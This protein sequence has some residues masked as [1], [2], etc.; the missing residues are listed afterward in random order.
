MKVLKFGGTSVGTASGRDNICTLALEKNER[1]IVVVSALSGVTDSLLAL[2]R[3]AAAGNK[4]NYE[5][6]LQALRK[7]HFEAIEQSTPIY[8]REEIKD[9][10]SS[11]IDKLTIEADEIYKNRELTAVADASVV[12]Y[13]ERLSSRILA[14]MMDDCAHIDSTQIIKTTPY[15]NRHIVDFPQT[16]HLI[17]EA[18]SKISSRIIVMGGFISSEAGNNETTNLGRGG[19]DYTAAIVA[20][21]LGVSTLYI[22]TDVDGFLSSDPRIVDNAILIEEL[23]FV[24]AMELCNFGAKV[25]YPPTIF[26]AYNADI[27]IVIRST[28]NHKCKGTTI[29][30]S[31]LMTS[32]SSVFKGISSINDTALLSIQGLK[33]FG[34]VGINYRLF[35]ALSAEGIS[36]FMVSQSSSNNITKVAIKNG[37]TQRAMEVIRSEF[38][39]E[40]ERGEIDECSVERNLAIIAVVGASLK[41]NREATA[42]ILNI[43]SDNGI[44]IIAS[45]QGGTQNSIAFVTEL[46]SLRRA[47]KVLHEALFIK[48]YDEVNIEIVGNNALS[49]TIKELVENSARKIME[50]YG[51][52][53]EISA[54]NSG[55]AVIV[56]CSKD[57]NLNYNELLN[58][59]KNIVSANRRAA[60]IE[61]YNHATSKYKCSATVGE[62]LPIMRALGDMVH[63]GD[64]INEIKGLVSGVIN[65]AMNLFAKGISMTTAMQ[66]AVNNYYDEVELEDEIGGKNCGK[67]IKILAQKCELCGDVTIEPLYDNSLTLGEIDAIW[68]EKRKVLSPNEKFVYIAE[69]TK[70]GARVYVDK[71]N[72]KEQ[73]YYTD[74]YNVAVLISSKR[75]REYPLQIKGYDTPNLEQIAGRVLSDILE[76]VGIT[77]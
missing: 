19:S 30:N 49:H 5:E 38:K 16:N 26:P 32:E 53:V 34:L 65:Y 66:T 3:E 73:L 56:D 40:I 58:S 77:L 50:R 25:V 76:I 55:C 71:V 13:G 72:D 61:N 39:G 44:N 47:T 28:N 62:G 74:N 23:G 37:D 41:E 52:K 36:V 57:T 6:I 70:E 18:V 8:I 31:S 12:A 60:A 29:K 67:R 21:A 68:E 4:S 35:R 17:N 7:R 63:S 27:P 9:Y 1:T 69:C 42:Q 64:E 59:G 2:G 10:C 45:A 33:N 24:E 51:L 15:F 20:S 43:L 48:H 46:S 75:Y 14:S 11:L 54:K 22:Y